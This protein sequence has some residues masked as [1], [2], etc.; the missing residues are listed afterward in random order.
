MKSNTFVLMLDA[1]KAFDQV[2]YCKLFI[3]KQDTKS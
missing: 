3:Y 2:N 1:S